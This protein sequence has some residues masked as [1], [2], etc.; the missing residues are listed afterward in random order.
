MLCQNYSKILCHTFIWTANYRKFQHSPKKAVC[1]NI[2]RCQRQN[3][4]TTKII[5]G[6]LS[7]TA[8]LDN[9]AIQR[10]SIF[11][12]GLSNLFMLYDLEHAVFLWNGCSGSANIRRAPLCDIASHWNHK[13]FLIDLT[14]LLLVSVFLHITDRCRLLMPH[15]VQSCG[16]RTTTKLFYNGI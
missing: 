5:S 4:R 2:Y 3:T 16:T 15:D 6:M 7:S 1:S 11:T 10:Y 9:V 14:K 8:S 12:S 13:I